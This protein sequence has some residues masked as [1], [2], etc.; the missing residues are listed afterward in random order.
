MITENKQ[1]I[2]E[3]LDNLSDNYLEDVVAYLRFLEY[4]QKYEKIDMSSM[5]LSEKSLSKE[6]LSNEE[7]VACLH[8]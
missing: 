1:I 2:I 3:S 4:K 5:L 6:W 8:L 7:E